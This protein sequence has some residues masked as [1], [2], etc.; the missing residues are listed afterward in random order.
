MQLPHDASETDQV[1][2]KLI[3]EISTRCRQ[4]QP[5]DEAELYRTHPQYA[6]QLAR[7]LPTLRVLAEL[8]DGVLG[9]EHAP[10]DEPLTAPM[11]DYRIIREIGRGGMGIIYEAEQISL[12]RLVALKV[13]PF[14]AM[15]S[16][17]QLQR[18]KNE[19]RAAAVLHHQNIVPVYGVGCHR[20]VHFYAMQLI[21]G[22]SLAEVVEDLRTL[23]G[24]ANKAA[25]NKEA[26]DVAQSPDQDTGA[27]EQLMVLARA[28]E[29]ACATE[30]QH[31]AS[32][33][34]VS[35]ASCRGGDSHDAAFCDTRAIGHASMATSRADLSSMAFFRGVARLGL[36]AAEA[37]QHAHEHGIV[38]RDIKPANLLLDADGKLWIT[39]FGLA[40][41]Q[42][43]AG[44]SISGDIIGTLR[45]MSPEQATG[46]VGLIASGT[47]IYS[48]GATLYELLTLEPAFPGNDRQ[49]LLRRVELQ[50]PV[51][52]RHLNG[53][54]PRDLET[55][56][57]K[58]MAKQPSDRYATA[59]HFASDLRCFLEHRPVA[60]RSPT[61]VQRVFKWTRRHQSAAFALSSIALLSIVGLLL[62]NFLIARQR[63]IAQRAFELADTQRTRAEAN[64]T[65]ALQAVND[66]LDRLARE[67]LRDVPQ[68]QVVRSEM[69]KRAVELLENIARQNPEDPAIWAE[70][71][72]G[73]AQLGQLSNEIGEYA[74]SQA[75]LH[76]AIGLF[77]CLIAAGNV[78][79][80]YSLGLARAH[81]ALGHVLRVQGKFGAAHSE[82]EKAL[83]ALQP[84]ENHA[85][86]H[87]QLQDVKGNTYQFVGRILNDQSRFSGAEEAYRQALAIQE[88][89]VERE[90]S[91]SHRR[92]LAVTLFNLGGL[93]FQTSDL[94]TAERNTR[95]AIDLFQT[96]V[97]E[98]PDDR[99]IREYWAS[100]Q[101]NL[102]MVLGKNG[103]IDEA[104]VAYRAHI[105]ALTKLVD[106]FPNIPDYRDT[107][108]VGHGNLAMLLR[109]QRDVDGAE[110]SAR[111]A[112]A[113]LSALVSQHPEV[114]LYRLHLASYQNNLG[115]ALQDKG[116]N[117]AAIEYLRQA[118]DNGEELVHANPHVE[119]YAE[120]LARHSR[121]LARSL[122]SGRQ[123]EAS[124]A[125]LTRTID[126]LQGLIVE[127]PGKKALYVELIGAWWMRGE[128]HLL[129]KSFDEAQAA[130]DQAL[131]IG[132]ETC[133]RFPEDPSIRETIAQRHGLY[134]HKLRYDFPA[135]EYRQ[136]VRGEMQHGIDLY[137]ALI[138]EC[139]GEK[140]HRLRLA[141][142]L[143]DLGNLLCAEGQETAAYDSYCRS[144]EISPIPGVKNQLA[145]LL[146][147]SRESQLRDA[148]RAIALARDAVGSKPDSMAYEAT[149]VLACLRLS[150]FE[151]ILLSTEGLTEASDE[152]SALCLLTRSLALWHLNRPEEALVC[153]RSVR[154]WI[155]EYSPVDGVLKELVCDAEEH[156]K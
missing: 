46:N 21:N 1:L 71:A 53:T 33:G 149:L 148:Q 134:A 67:R 42:Q 77:E 145:R 6:D 47:D 84:I 112:V 150:Q 22:K 52:P 63:N 156:F 29:D 31:T 129:L 54:I 107:L 105:T 117:D 85:V 121:N 10:P 154:Q 15:L 135:A 70:I 3:E 101:N 114:T 4:G 36:H 30:I 69:T 41:L 24:R 109:S 23:E 82:Y 140:N 89:I 110:T 56:V 50:E 68:M 34:Q 43:D 64:L 16:E 124:I 144:L 79:P 8:G 122:Q 133:E 57:L 128:D 35:I 58:A 38:H 51:R 147:S 98:T 115:N 74:E 86:D 138:A 119:E 44:I 26:C 45:Y 40:Q 72:N 25:S 87:G 81:N 60:A 78:P 111:S 32:P 106:D 37:L 120:Y 91:A 9:D 20:G 142:M 11:G 153:F 48:L 155:S 14:A 80:A 88:T 95:R 132:R 141:A 99:D 127:Q 126:L 2:V 108:A 66:M 49:A 152:H 96:L 100:S 94:S 146:V 118:V 61:L 76:R 7:V 136:F 131:K 27:Y 123:L 55:I 19:A 116:E 18:F 93:H 39:D 103:R 104:T 137:S 97:S 92:D 12:G 65:I 13:L 90:A 83:K 17:R 75:S 130:F 73:Y 28:G 59:A 113:I 151:Q 102:A 143:G 62:S 5:V 139:P 125:A